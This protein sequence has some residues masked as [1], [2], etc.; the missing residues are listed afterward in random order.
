MERREQLAEGYELAEHCRFIAAQIEGCLAKAQR[1]LLS[2]L[3]AVAQKVP[4]QDWAFWLQGNL[5]LVGD[6]L[7]EAQ[8][9]VQ[10]LRRKAQ[11]LVETQEGL[12]R[13]EARG[14]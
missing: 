7:I 13:G 2:I 9:H 5:E 12:L 14:R 11:E 8:E 10:S 6:H 4:H 3:K 1:R